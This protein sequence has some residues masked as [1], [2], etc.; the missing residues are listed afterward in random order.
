M[1][2]PLGTFSICYYLRVR[3]FVPYLCEEMDR[4]KHT[5]TFEQS[6]SSSFAGNKINETELV[7]CTYLLIYAM[8][9]SLSWEANRVCS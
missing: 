5:L 4:T 9:Q 6:W 7:A 3:N 1:Y 8:E 2:S